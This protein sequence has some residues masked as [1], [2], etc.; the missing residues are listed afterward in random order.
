M[1]HKD[2]QNVTDVF[3]KSIDGTEISQFNKICVTCVTK[4]CNVCY[5]SEILA[6]RVIILNPISGCFGPFIKNYKSK[7]HKKE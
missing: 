3:L 4:K 1:K 2:N 6:D 7:N 5:T